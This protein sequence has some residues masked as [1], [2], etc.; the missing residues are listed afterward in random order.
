MIALWQIENDFEVSCH[1][2]IKVLSR[3]LA[4]ETEENHERPQDG[5]YPAEIPTERL[6]NMNV[7]SYR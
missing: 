4:A 1:G 6:L 7:E 2:L 3:D 5:L